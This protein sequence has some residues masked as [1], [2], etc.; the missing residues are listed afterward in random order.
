MSIGKRTGFDFSKHKLHETRND[1]L[2]MYHLKKPGTSHDNIKYINVGGIMAVTGDY[3]NWIFCREFVPSAD[4]Y[5]SDEYWIEKLHIASSQKGKEYDSHATE[6]AIK[7]RN[8]EEE[9]W[10]GKELQEMKEYLENCLRY[11][12]NEFEYTSY[13]YGH[14]PSFID[15]ESVTFVENT[16]YWLLMVFDGFDEI[17]RL[18]NKKTEIC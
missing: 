8:L 6:A 3:G 12:D 11:V 18:L 15:N 7:A 1:N 9:G 13:A 4:G 14:T 17:C 5:V 2:I 10:Q 16:K